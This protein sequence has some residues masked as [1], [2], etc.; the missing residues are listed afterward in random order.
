MLAADRGK[1]VMI[2]PARAPPP[3]LFGAVSASDQNPDGPIAWLLGLLKD[4]AA[5]V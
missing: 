2:E 5:G 3:T 1:V 4:A